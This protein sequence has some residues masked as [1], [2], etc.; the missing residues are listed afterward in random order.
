MTSRSFTGG[1]PRCFCPHSTQQQ[2]F[3]VCFTPPTSRPAPQIEQ[4][5]RFV[6][7]HAQILLNQYKH[8]PAKAVRESAFAA[9]LKSQMELR[10]H[11]KL[12]VRPAKQVHIQHWVE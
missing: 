2:S 8:F 11:A 12:Y 3:R 5:Q 4:V 10:R 9:G 6:V 7:V 1:Q